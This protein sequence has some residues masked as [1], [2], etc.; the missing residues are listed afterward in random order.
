[1]SKEFWDQRYAG[2]GFVYGHHPNLFFCRE[3]RKLKPGRL[4]LPGEGEGRNAV[5]AARL[6]WDVVAFDQSRE[7]QR[8][9]LELAADKKVK[10][11]Y[12]AVSLEE[13]KVKPEYF[14]CLA[15]IFVHFPI[16][17]RKY[18]HRKLLTYLKPG[19]VMIMEVFSK[20]QLGKPS[21]GPQH[22]DMLYSEKELLEDFSELKLNQ[23]QHLDTELN[24]G[25]YHEGIA[26]VIRLTGRK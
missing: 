5:Y 17:Q 12:E 8:K 21:G 18:F 14:D 19:G 9:A 7:G 1:M 16:D 4:L 24:E 6:G 23:V 22:L 20:D 3:I 2:D 13:F 10:I 15:L 11:H 25:R 26:S